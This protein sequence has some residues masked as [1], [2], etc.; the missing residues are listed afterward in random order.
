MTF[1]ATHVTDPL[2]AAADVYAEA[3][4][5]GYRFPSPARVPDKTRLR[6]LE[7]AVVAFHDAVVTIAAEAEG[8]D[9]ITRAKP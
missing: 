5:P 4:I 7:D 6:A 1:L 3:T 9:R 8:I 2:E